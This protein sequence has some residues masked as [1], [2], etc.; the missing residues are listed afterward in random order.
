IA[1]WFAVAEVILSAHEMTSAATIASSTTHDAPP[2]SST[3]T[4]AIATPAIT[5]TLRSTA[6]VSDWFTLGCTTRS[7]AIAANTGGGPSKSHPARSHATTVAS[8]DLM[9]SSSGGRFD[10]RNEATRRIPSRYAT[11]VPRS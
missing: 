4:V 10:A 1:T 5:P 6:F 8:A 11:A 9:T 2:S 7:A 3:T